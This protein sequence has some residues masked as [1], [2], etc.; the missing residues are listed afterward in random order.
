ME[1]IEKHKVRALVYENSIFT[2]VARKKE[3]ITIRIE[4]IAN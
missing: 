3:V 4:T 2:T 1:Y